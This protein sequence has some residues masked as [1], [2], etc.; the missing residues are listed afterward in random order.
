MSLRRGL[1]NQSLGGAVLV[2]ATMTAAALGASGS[3]AAAVTAASAASASPASD[4]SPTTPSAV[5]QVETLADADGPY[6]WRVRGP[7]GRWALPVGD[8]VLLQEAWWTPLRPL[9]ALPGPRPD[10]AMLRRIR[11]QVAPSATRR[12][13]D[14]LYDVA[15]GD[16][17]L[18]GSPE[19]AIAHRRPF[20]RTFINITRPRGAWTDRY[21]LSAHLGLYRPHAVS[22][23]WVAGTLTRPVVKLAACDGALGVAYGSLHRPGI[24]ETSA[25]RWVVF[26]FLP[27]ETLPGRGTPVCVDI[28]GDGRTEPAITERS[29]S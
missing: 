17:T 19:V 21:G 7:D 22:P 9:V 4:A 18:D 2:A 16:V 29:A 1:P 10:Q 20:R 13:P 25:W 15:I 26:G 5:G 24:V 28:D 12:L 6:A 27:A 3:D 8:A 23:I 11:A 14:R